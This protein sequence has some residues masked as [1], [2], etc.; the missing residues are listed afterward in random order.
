MKTLVAALMLPVA[1]IVLDGCMVGPKY[2]KPSTPTAPAFKEQNTLSTEAKDGWRPAQPNDQTL[3]GNWWEIYDDPQLNALEVQIA[4]ANQTL[5][6]AEANY[7]EA[8]TAIRFNRSAEAPAIGVAPGISTVRDSANQPYFPSGLANNGTGDFILPVDLS[9]EID[10]WGR[11]RRS[12]TAAKEQTQAS[13]AD[14]A[15][16]RLSLQAELA[17]D[18]FELRSADAEK[19]LLDDTVQAYSKALGLT[20]YRFEGGAAP[21]SDVAQARTQLKDAQVLDT[22]IMVQRAEF[23]HAIAILIGKPPANFSLSPIPIDLQ[24]PAIPPIPAVLPSELLERR[25]DIA[26]SE[27]RVAAANEQIGIA[28]AAYY[29]TLNLSALAGFEGTSA[30]NWFNWPSRFWAVGPSLSET[31]FDAGRR[32]ATKESAIAAYDGNVANY[33]QTTLT[34]FQ[35][36]EDNLVV[37]R[38]LAGESQ[39]QRDATAAAEETLRIFMN[40]Y[41]GGVDTYLQVVTSQTTALSNEQNDID[42]RRRQLDAGVLLIKALGGGWD[43]SQ[44]PRL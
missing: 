37:L 24:T 7:R 6:I 17:F 10:L 12:V 43:T 2:A 26:A 14:M 28:Q 21:K 36:V 27:R 9:W 5:K 40:R 22:D 30:S 25:P 38:I 29:P 20:K 31:L 32:R 16:A 42:I 35:Q 3:R 8:R 18:Y 11:I 1:T 44:L 39:Q 19:K 4:S 15:A 41:A 34:A 23:E 33:R 13:A